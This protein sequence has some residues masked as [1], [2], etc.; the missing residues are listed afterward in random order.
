MMLLSDA[1]MLSRLVVVGFLCVALACGE[2]SDSSGGGTGAT[3]GASG[4]GAMGGASGAGAIGGAGAMGGAAGTTGGAAGTTGG[5]AGASGGTAGTTG[6]TAGAS[7]GS[8]NGG[9][10]G[11]PGIQCGSAVCTGTQECVICDLGGTQLPKKCAE[12][13]QANCT[14]YPILRMSCDDH[15]DCPSG[16]SCG[17]YEGALG[18]YVQCAAA[19]SCA[20]DCSCPGGTYA[21][22]CTTL[23]DCPACATSCGAY[24]PYPG[25]PSIPVNVCRW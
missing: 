23:A 8:G 24:E 10:A 1:R 3:G 4:S 7:G 15:G 5:T 6:G 16:E 21:R 14:A 2:S 25:A 18:T 22:V 9:A 11:G 19:D 17:V 20:N 12:P 13:N